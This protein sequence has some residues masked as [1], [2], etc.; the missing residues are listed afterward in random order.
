MSAPPYR[1][2]VMTGT[3]ASALVRHC[4]ASLSSKGDN[5]TDAIAGAELTSRYKRYDVALSGE[6][7]LRPVC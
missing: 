4:P 5:K 3:I 1:S 6:I 2:H 7:L